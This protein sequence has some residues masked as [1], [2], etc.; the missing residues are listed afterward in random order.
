MLGFKSQNK[1]FIIELAL[2]VL[3]YFKKNV[4]NYGIN[5]INAN[6]FNMK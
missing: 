6:F 4:K 2:S 3:T 5:H 1:Q